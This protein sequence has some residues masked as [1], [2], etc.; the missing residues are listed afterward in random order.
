M[1][2][3]CHVTSRFEHGPAGRAGLEV[4][5]RIDSIGGRQVAQMSPAAVRSAFLSVPMNGLQLQVVHT[6]SGTTE[7]VELP[8]GPIYPLYRE[9]DLVH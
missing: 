2:G 4:G 8:E 5:D 7:T 9:Q 1:A 6:G 3:K